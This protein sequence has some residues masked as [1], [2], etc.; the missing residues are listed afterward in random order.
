MSIVG[1]LALHF[2]EFGR[3]AQMLDTHS[4]R[5][6]LFCKHSWQGF[7]LCAFMFSFSGCVYMLPPRAGPREDAL[8]TMS[9]LGNSLYSGPLIILSSGRKL[10]ITQTDSQLRRVS[11]VLSSLFVKTVKKSILGHNSCLFLICQRATI[12]I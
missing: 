3:I 12:L 6:V 4:P 11:Y 10:A 9:L 5:N 8:Y 7:K 2:L 1:I